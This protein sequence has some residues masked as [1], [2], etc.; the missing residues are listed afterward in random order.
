MFFDKSQKFLFRCEDC[1][2]VLEAK[3]EEQKDIDGVNEN[4]INIE[5]PC[6]GIAKVIRN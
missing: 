1:D 5:C 2:T 4:E 6:K 3:F